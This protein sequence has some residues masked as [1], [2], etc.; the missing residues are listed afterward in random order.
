MSGPRRAEEGA[1]FSLPEISAL[2]VLA[3]VVA[4]ARELIS[5]A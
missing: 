2:A 3:A 4:A 1:H 5:S